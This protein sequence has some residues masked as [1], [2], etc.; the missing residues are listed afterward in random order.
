MIFRQQ[1]V[2]KRFPF[3]LPPAPQAGQRKPYGRVGVLPAVFPEALAVAA[4]IAGAVLTRVW[5]RKEL[6]DAVLPIHKL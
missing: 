5:R 2:K 6:Y 1:H 3:T 4:E